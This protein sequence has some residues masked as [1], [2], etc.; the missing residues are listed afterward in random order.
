MHLIDRDNVKDF[1]YENLIKYY[2][3][4]R[5]EVTEESYSKFFAIP[6]MNKKIIKILN[7]ENQEDICDKLK[8]YLDKDWYKSHKDCYWYNSHKR[9]PDSFYGYWAFEVAA[10]VKIKGLDDST[11]RDNKYYPD[12][13]L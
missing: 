5:K 11:F 12:R 1:L 8:S 13:L 9:Y 4:E 10:I 6:N 3:P 7:D 2:Y